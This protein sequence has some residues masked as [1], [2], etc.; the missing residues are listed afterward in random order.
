MLADAPPGGVVGRM[1]SE[2]VAE[3]GVSTCDLGGAPVAD[4]SAN[5]TPPIDSKVAIKVA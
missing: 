4:G 3:P 5:A 1:V 2:P